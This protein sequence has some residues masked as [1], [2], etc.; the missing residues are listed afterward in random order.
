MENV[1]NLH[2]MFYDSIKIRFS[3]VALLRTYWNKMHKKWLAIA[4]S[5]EDQGMI[6]ILELVKK[7]PETIVDF[8]LHQYVKSCVMR[9]ILAFIQWRMLFSKSRLES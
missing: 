8:L 1:N 2:D 9:H 4:T 6:R 5:E 7:V 3:K